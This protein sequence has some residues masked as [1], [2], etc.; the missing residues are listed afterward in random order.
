[1]L[2][3][4]NTNK[5]ALFSLGLAAGAAVILGGQTVLAQMSGPKEHKGLKVDLLQELSED[6][7]EATMGLTGYTMRMRSIEIEPGGQIAEHSH[8]ERPGL[9][10]VIEGEWV[11]G[12]PDGEETFAGTDLG[13]LPEKEDTVHWFYN[14]TDKPATALVCD[15][16]PVS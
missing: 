16:A 8:A 9:V 12:E 3:L 1:M 14:R 2:K 10:T 15:F 5:S 13:T 6:T 4:F 7:L 11:E